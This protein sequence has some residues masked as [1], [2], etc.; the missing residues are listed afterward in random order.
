MS[1]FNILLV[2]TVTG[3]TTACNNYCS[4]SLDITE[5]FFEEDC[6]GDVPFIE[7][8]VLMVHGSVCDSQRNTMK[9]PFFHNTIKWLIDS[10][11][12]DVPNCQ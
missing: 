3:I 8:F 2:L 6:K 9:N 1:V 11:C 10:D 7:T 5:C 12:G 4:C